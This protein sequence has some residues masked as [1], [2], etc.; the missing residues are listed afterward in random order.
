MA[1]TGIY[2][3]RRRTAYFFVPESENAKPAFDDTVMFH[4]AVHQLFNETSQV[5]AMPGEK[6]NFWLIE[7]IACYFE[8]LAERDGSLMLGGLDAERTNA[9][10]VRLFNDN[11]YLPLAELCGMRRLSV[12]RDP[13]IAPIYTQSAGLTH[14]LIHSDRGSRRHGLLAALKAVYNGRDD[15]GTLSGSLNQSYTDLDSAYRAFMQGGK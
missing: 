4:E 10:R 15:V 5:I 8:S 6:Q 3:S 1:T 13:R 7:G 12:Q 2:I 9:A 14:F 11:F